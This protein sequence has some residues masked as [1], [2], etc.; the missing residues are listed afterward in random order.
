[1]PHYL[2][3]YTPDVPSSGP[4]SPE[5]MA[6]MGKLIEKM[7]ARNALVTMGATVP[8]SFAVRLVKGAYSMR[9]VPRSGEQ[10]F[11]ILNARDKDDALQMAREFLAVA[12]DGESVLH[13]L[14][15]QPPQS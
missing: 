12:G 15:S 6:A 9:D 10:G 8:G 7:N 1:M 5:H 11:A 3:L 4:P 13:P 2:T 14:M